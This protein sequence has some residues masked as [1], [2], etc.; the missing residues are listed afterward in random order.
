MKSSLIRRAAIDN[1]GKFLK[2]ARNDIKTKGML[3]PIALVIIFILAV[4]G[5]A[6]YNY[7]RFERNL[8]AR[9]Q[10]S[11]VAE[12][13]AQAAA[14][15][16]SNWYNCKAL[17]LKGLD[18]T[19]P[20]DRF[21]LAPVIEGNVNS[22]TISLTPNELKSFALIAGLS[23]TLDSVE[24]K[25]EGFSSYFNPPAEPSDYSSGCIIASDPFERFGGLVITSKVSYRTITRVFC[26]RYEAKIA[27]TLVP[28]L[29]KFTFFTSGKDTA[30]ENQLKMVTLAD[31]GNQDYG[32][33]GIVSKTETPLRAPLIMVH[34]P[35]DIAEVNASGYYKNHSEIREYL[36][37]DETVASSAPGGSGVTYRPSM[38]DRGWVY[39]GVESS[40]NSYYLLNI[41]PGKVNPDA[42]NPYPQNLNYRFY[43]NGFLLLE[44]DLCALVFNALKGA[45]PYNFSFSDAQK[46][47]GVHDYIIRLTQ[48]GIYWILKH[49][50]ALPIIGN[51]YAANPDMVE[52]SSLLQL[53]GDMQAKAFAVSIKPSRYLDRRSPT[54]VFG[55]VVRSFASVG[56]ICQ[57]C[58]HPPG[59]PNAGS[60]LTNGMH[61]MPFEICPGAHPRVF[62]L[63]FFNI[64]D[65]GTLGANSVLSID[66]ADWDGQR[67]LDDTIDAAG[68]P[69]P[70]STAVDFAKVSADAKNDIFKLTDANHFKNYKFFMSKIMFEAYNKS[71]NWITANSKPAEGIIEPGPKY[72]L[73]QNKIKILK[74]YPNSQ[75]D[76]LFFYNQGSVFGNCINAGNLKISQYSKESGVFSEAND[77]FADGI[78]R[79]SLAAVS[80]A[81][82]GYVNPMTAAAPAQ[83]TEYD[84][85]HKASHI[86]NTFGE[87]K[88]ALLKTDAGTAELKD[89]GVFY[90][91][92]GGE[93]DLTQNAQIQ[94]ILFHDNAMLIFKK[95]VKIPSINKSAYAKQNGCTLSIVSVDGD[96]TICGPE[97]EASINS[98]GGTIKKAVDYFQVFGN[99]SMKK[100]YFNLSS[101]GNLFKVSAIPSGSAS[102]ILGAKNGEKGFTRMSVTYDPALDPC[103]AE[104]YLYHYKFYVSSR[105]TY[106][107]FYSE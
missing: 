1:A 57:N 21:V 16:A 88:A 64:D 79:G 96:I 46:P 71:Y 55:R 77:L 44:S 66:D 4:L 48:A 42:F 80:L 107:R 14:Y 65:S 60:V 20:I 94:K 40:P 19:N 61:K 6:L 102:D 54:V 22:L 50:A 8:V 30:S 7:V 39:L 63:P 62:F 18:K 90:I 32:G 41:S 72:N 43:G 100:I 89:S 73:N 58:M 86:F 76:E 105:Q 56:N 91:D 13:M 28:L 15:E 24:L 36:P 97:I 51:F 3:V 69:Y 92:E 67:I 25:Y 103:D 5:I 23:G 68:V 75:P 53:S 35:E 27:N 70:A 106:W 101:P 9:L 84:I 37:L 12:K 26:C 11:S 83:Q 74:S 52:H 87:F 29:S 81:S 99:M 78:F 17:Y 59:S 38:T 31:S 45:Y 82:A 85:R 10:Y 93:S 49:P 34:H 33:Q 47:P 98:L 104:N 2:N 95:G